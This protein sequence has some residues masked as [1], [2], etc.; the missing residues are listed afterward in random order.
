MAG[1]SG[2]F[3]GKGKGSM[4]VAWGGEERKGQPLI[5]RCQADRVPVDAIIFSNAGTRSA[6]QRV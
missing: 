4:R 5:A 3:K 2:S 1:D 6:E